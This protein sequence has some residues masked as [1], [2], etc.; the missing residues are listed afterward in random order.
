MFMPVGTL[1]T[2][3]AMSP[4]ELVELGA[5]IILC[6]TYHLYLRPG[7]D[8]VREAGG[9]HS[10][11]GWQ[12]PILTD[13]G[14]F[15]VFSL[16][17]LRKIVEDGVWFRSH[18]DG[19]SHFIGPREAMRIQEDLGADII[20]C[21]DVCPPYPASREEV[22]RAVAR[23]LDWAR[24][25]RETHDKPEQALFGIVQ[26]GVHKD[27][28]EACARALVDLDFPGYAVG[29]LSVG[30]PK[31]DMNDTVAWT[32][33]FLPTEKPRYLMGVGAPDDLIEGISR[34]IDMF[35][36]VLPTRIARHGSV[37]T[38]RGQITIRNAEYARD[39]TPL[40]PECGCYTC[41]RFT[42]AYI[43]HLLKANE[44]LGMRLTTYHNL[45]FLRD[46]VARA[47][48]AIIA[49]EFEA[50]KAETLARIAPSR[51]NRKRG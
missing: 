24:I 45:A 51:A 9:L 35:D 21:F 46:L 6:N 14:G 27:L 10:F 43:R 3:K 1:G 34:G 2:V 36:C 13:S 44:I 15:Q 16:S 42:R 50:W 39:F 49:G 23:T 20:M 28:R 41:K 19:S 11:I 40:D 30:E 12:R 29:G 26:G 8:V 18:L 38:W 31:E 5:R 33:Q 7:A 22:E 37:F 17:G 4:D 25:C 47:R 48:D 32:L